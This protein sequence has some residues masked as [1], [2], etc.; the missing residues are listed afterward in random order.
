MRYP[1][2]IATLLFSTPVLANEG[3]KMAVPQFDPSSFPSQLFWLAVCF[4]VLYVLMA[5]IALPR[6]GFVVEQRAARV[7]QDVT[8]AK[9][10]AAEA[11]T[12][13][14]A[15]EA[16]LLDARNKARESLGDATAAAVAAQTAKL[17][18]QNTQLVA[19]L[20]EAEAKIAAA[21]QTA[22]ANITPTAAATAASVLSKLTG[23][24]KDAASLN[25][26][27]DTAMKKGA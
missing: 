15:Y 8:A 12:L 16:S 26:A 27:I 20:Q 17:S 18:L 3:E 1:V 9:I 6:V 22:L 4:A 7:E 13:Q 5:K 10:A 23:I 21:R 24:T 11:T 25:T 19:R 2:L 14:A